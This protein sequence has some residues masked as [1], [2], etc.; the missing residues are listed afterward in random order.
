MSKKNIYLPRLKVCKPK[1]TFKVP[2]TDI[3]IVEVSIRCFKS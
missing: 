1:E 3:V 2:C